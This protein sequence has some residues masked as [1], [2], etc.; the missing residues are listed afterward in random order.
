MGVYLFEAKSVDG[1]ALKG[2]VKAESESEAKNKLRR[3]KLIS[4]EVRVKG[5]RADKAIYK[6]AVGIPRKVK[7]REVRYFTRQLAALLESG[8]PLEQSLLSTISPGAPTA[9]NKVVVVTLSNV[10]AGHSLSSSM[11]MFPK[12]FN[13]IYTRIVAVAEE[14]GALVEMFNGLADYM[15]Q[16]E[17]I[18]A[19]LARSMWYPII[20]ILVVVAVCSSLMAFVIPTF[21][22]VFDASGQSLPGITLMLIGVSRFFLA[23]WWL[24]FGV[25]G[26]SIICVKWAIGKPLGRRILDNFVLY[27]PVIGG[28][29]KKGAVG[30]VSRILSLLI[31]AHVMLSDALEL[32]AGISG[33]SVVDR[34]ML[35]AKAELMKGG[36]L[37]VVLRR[38]PIIPR[39]MP[40]MVAVGES[41]GNLPVMFESLANFYEDELEDGLQAMLN[42]IEPIIIIFVGII[43]SVIAV[44]M[45]L[46]MF[47]LGNV[48]LQLEL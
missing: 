44:A 11:S 38:H 41:T 14:S 3:Q 28:I 33:N 32:A 30:Q 17:K 27:I 39:L 21:V 12:V 29:V 7:R 35:K 23:Y 9:L 34:V 4:I 16:S 10:R 26:L 8:V 43:V 25:G 37:S 20:I 36:S 1:K 31:N 42:L 24:F 13:R 47:S 5:G 2:E 15:D 46:P 40:D 22:K 19:Q 6:K 48:A 18:R 45:Y